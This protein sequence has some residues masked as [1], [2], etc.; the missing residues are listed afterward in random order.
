[1]LLA[2]A[3]VKVENQNYTPIISEQH[4]KGLFEEDKIKK[5]IDWYRAS[6][7]SQLA[8]DQIY[9]QKLDNI[10][11]Y[12]NLG[13]DHL[14][15]LVCRSVLDPVEQGYLMKNLEHLYNDQDGVLGTTAKDIL[16]NPL[17]YTNQDIKLKA[18]KR[19]TQATANYINE[20][21]IPAITERGE[22]IKELSDKTIQLEAESFR[23]KKEAERMNSCCKW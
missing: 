1:M 9:L 2:I 11:Y 23:F 7:P 12:Y 6:A 15:L 10:H 16:S 20:V 21:L 4:R 14:R 17:A 3:V 5:F 22:T 19:E 8:A 18:I 13:N